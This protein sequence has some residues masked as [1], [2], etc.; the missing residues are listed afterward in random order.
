MHVAAFIGKLQHFK[1]WQPSYLSTRKWV[2]SPFLSYQVTNMPLYHLGYKNKAKIFKFSMARRVRWCIVF[3]DLKHFLP[4]SALNLVVGPFLFLYLQL[5]TVWPL[6]T[7]STFPS[8]FP[9]F[10]QLWP[11]LTVKVLFFLW[12]LLQ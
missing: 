1:N 10:L 7:K 12:L 9:Y 8:L 5:R 11:L 2:I 4:I 3:V 6:L